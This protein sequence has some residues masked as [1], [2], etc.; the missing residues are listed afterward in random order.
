MS[1]I[2]QAIYDFLTTE[3][4]SGDTTRDQNRQDLRNIIGTRI[5]RHARRPQAVT[6]PSLTMDRIAGDVLSSVSKSPRCVVPILSFSI[7]TSDN[8][9]ASIAERAY[10]LLRDIFHQYRGKLNDAITVKT[11][12]IQS[13]PYERSYKPDDGSDIWLHETI[14]SVSFAYNT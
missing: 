3:T 13:E 7:W 10:S 2:K 8:D 5:Y 6:K 14:F 4:T 9:E 11:T 1:D 12:Q